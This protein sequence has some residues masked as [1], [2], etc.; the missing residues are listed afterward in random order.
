MSRTLSHR[1]QR[2]ESAA[3]SSRVPQAVPVFFAWPGQP[4]PMIPAG[5]MAV[6]VRVVDSSKSKP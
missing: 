6:V 4:A 5:R 3:L 2:L 1:I